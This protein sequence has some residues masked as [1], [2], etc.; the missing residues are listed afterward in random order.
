[1]N[2]S[3]SL[4]GPSRPPLAGGRPGR[5]V[6]F[7]HGYGAD[8]RDLLELGALWAP[9]MPDALFLA[10]NAPFPCEASPYG[11]QWFGFEGRDDASRYAGVLAAASILD[12]FID[13]TL[14]RHGL[15]PDRLALVGFSQGTMMALHVA[16][17]RAEA[18]AGIVGFSGALVAPERLSHE[19][20][21]RPPV[22]L[23]HGTADP[24]VP[25]AALGL[26]KSALAAAG[27]AVTAESR[28]GLPHAIDEPGLTLALRFLRDR[29]AG[30]GAAIA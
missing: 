19:G 30:V 15:G 16:P 28:P 25:Y 22:L 26:A 23:V 1:M 6:L 11:F 13:E 20:R 14:A 7:L 21:S 29:F 4:T 10:P 8:G 18:L 3:L 24:V 5:V 17:R 27:I 9:S 12:A 2:L